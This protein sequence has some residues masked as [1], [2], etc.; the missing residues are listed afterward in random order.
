VD[1]VHPVSIR[2]VGWRLPLSSHDAA[3]TDFHEKVI[4]GVLSDALAA[5]GTSRL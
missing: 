2:A 5:P 1:L 4:L 3:F